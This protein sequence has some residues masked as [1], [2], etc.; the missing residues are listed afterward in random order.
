[1]IQSAPGTDFW[2]V[3]HDGTVHDT[4][5]FYYQQQTG[6]FQADVKISGDYRA[7]YDQAGLMVRLDEANWIKC[8]IEF[9]DGLQHASAV[10]TRDY[11]DW[12]IV[13]LHNS[14]ASF[15][16]RVQRQGPTIEISYGFDGRNY[17]LLRQAYLTTVPTLDVGLMCA[18]PQGSGFSSKFEYLRIQSL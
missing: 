4:G 11:S 14:P 12:S 18:A 6:D 5:H 7:L 13:R 9:V 16:L 2:R 15:W 3:T 8:G 1:M 17:Q 10:V